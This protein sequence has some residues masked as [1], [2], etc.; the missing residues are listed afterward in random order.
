MRRKKYKSS[1]QNTIHFFLNL[2]FSSWTRKA[3]SQLVIL[4]LK[5]QMAERIMGDYL[6]RWN[7]TPQRPTK[8]VYQRDLKSP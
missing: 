4:K 6:K 2:N 3:I 5:K 1:S 8:K 7:F